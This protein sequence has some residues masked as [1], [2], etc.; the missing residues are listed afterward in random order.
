MSRDD[1]DK[2]NR[3]YRDGAY[4]ERKHPSAVLVD[5]LAEAPA[6]PALDVACGAGRNA[7]YLAST[8]RAVDAVDISGAALERG[9]EAAAERGLHVRFIEADLEHDPDQAL[10]PGPYALI[11]V[12]RYVH[13]AILPA[14]LSRLEPGGMLLVEQHVD[15]AEPVIGPTTAAYRMRPQEL[16]RLAR[17]AGADPAEIRAY[18]EGLVADPDGRT[19]ALAQLVLAKRHT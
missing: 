4:A 15:S 1:R 2:W 12:V 10:P 11:V 16:L 17:E 7:L 13:R 18:R 9:R 3:R 5:R 19:A 6:G 14:L 8:G